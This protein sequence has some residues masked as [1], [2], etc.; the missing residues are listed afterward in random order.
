MI[1][2][3]RSSDGCWIRSGCTPTCPIGGGGQAKDRAVSGDSLLRTFAIH[4]R[5]LLFC[6]RIIPCILPS[7]GPVGPCSDSTEAL[8]GQRDRPS[9]TDDRL[10]GMPLERSGEK[11]PSN[12]PSHEDCLMMGQG[13]F[14]LIAQGGVT[15]VILAIFSI[16]SLAVIGERIYKI[17][18]AHV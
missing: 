8:Q 18:R 2:W 13:V 16:F 3:T 17:G 12:Y 11:D 14:H 5:S 7:L 15:M 1:W 6:V 9:G 4:F 10:I